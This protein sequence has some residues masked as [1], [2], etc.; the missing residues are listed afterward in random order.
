M[1]SGSLP[2]ISAGGGFTGTAGKGLFTAPTWTSLDY[3]TLCMPDCQQ[4]SLTTTSKS[5]DSNHSSDRYNEV[6]CAVLVQLRYAE[7]IKQQCIVYTGND[8]R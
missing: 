8:I 2:M 3:N 7:C 6:C 1:V 5:N 4:Q